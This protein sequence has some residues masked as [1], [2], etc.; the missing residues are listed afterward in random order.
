M[1]LPHGQEGQGPEH[2]SAR[3]ERYLQLCAQENM[4]VCQPTT[5]AQI[6]HLLRM[7]AMLD[8]RV[9]LVVMTPKSLLRHPEAV[10]SLEDL[11]NGRFNE[12]LA[13]SPTE[14][15]A[16][17]VERVI[18]CSG[19]VYFDLLER[20]RKSKKDNIALIRVEQLYPFPAKQISSELTRY[21]NLKSVVWCQE[22]SKNQGSWN[23]VLEQMLEIVKAP[24]A[25]QY[26]GPEAT[27]STAPGYASMHV[28]RQEKYLHAAIDE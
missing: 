21:P 1:L 17:K 22:E 13:E 7:Q 5:P 24:A 11:A 27:A 6:F 2:A 10:S 25:L 9:P 15:A 18:L 23:F 3:L 28:A 26:I 12:I 19:K 14:E 16:S 4:R 20:R 8:D